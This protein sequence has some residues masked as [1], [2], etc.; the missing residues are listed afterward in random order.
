MIET[1]NLLKNWTNQIRQ[2]RFQGQESKPRKDFSQGYGFQNS[3]QTAEMS[4][5]PSR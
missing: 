4:A 1:L 5:P 3:S 2:I